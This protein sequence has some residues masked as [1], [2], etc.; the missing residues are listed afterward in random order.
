MIICPVSLLIT[1]IHINLMQKNFENKV[2]NTINIL[3][4]NKHIGDY[5]S[6]VNFT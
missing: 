1:I 6:I 5:V 2:M 4:H 3:S